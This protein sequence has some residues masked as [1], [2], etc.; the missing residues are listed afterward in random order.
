MWTRMVALV[1]LVGLSLPALA[2]ADYY[3]YDGDW[4]NVL[5]RDK[6]VTSGQGFYNYSGDWR[7]TYRVYPYNE[8][9]YS[10][11]YEPVQVITGDV[12]F[13]P[14]IMI[15]APPYGGAVYA[16]QPPRQSGYYFTGRQRGNPQ[17]SFRPRRR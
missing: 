1:A 5:L 7:E 2:Y 17:F 14:F 13:V 15:G 16:F 4:K 11:P 9:T 3:S 6:G 12:P 8:Q 10:L